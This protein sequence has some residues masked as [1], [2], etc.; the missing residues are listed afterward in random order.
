MKVCVK[1]LDFC[2]VALRKRLK[3]SRAG[4]PACSDGAEKRSAYPDH[5]LVDEN[6]KKAQP[7]FSLLLYLFTSF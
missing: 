4:L 6:R 2:Q 5:Y 3:A 1:N 7:I